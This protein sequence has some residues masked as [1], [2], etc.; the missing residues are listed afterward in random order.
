MAAC[1]TVLLVLWRPC[2][3]RHAKHRQAGCKVI[4]TLLLLMQLAQDA[5]AGEQLQAQEGTQAS[6]GQHR[7]AGQLRHAAVDGRSNKLGDQR[8]QVFVPLQTCVLCIAPRRLLKRADD[9]SIL[10]ISFAC[11]WRMAGLLNRAS[12]G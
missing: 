4:C 5:L 6:R 1:I 12:K 11:D 9:T 3:C 7:L 8:L 10:S 2:T